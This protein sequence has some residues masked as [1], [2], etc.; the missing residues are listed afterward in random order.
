MEITNSKFNTLPEQVQENKDNINALNERIMS[1]NVY[2]AKIE[3]AQDASAILAEDIKNFDASKTNGYVLDTAGKLFKIVAVDND[4]VYID[5]AATL[6]RG[7]QGERG[8]RGLTGEVGP[9][10]IQGLTGEVGPVGPR[11][12]QGLTGATGDAGVGI[13]SI[14]AGTPSQS[15]NNTVTP[16]TITLTNGNTQL[17][18]IYATNG[19]DG[20]QGNSFIITG[21]VNSVVDLPDVSTVAYGTA[22]YVGTTY[23]RDVFVVVEYQGAKIWQNEGKL[24]GP[25]GPVGPVGATGANGIN[26][27]DGVGIASITAGTPS[28]SG[29]NTVTPLTITLT[30]NNTVNFNVEAQNGQD[31]AQGPQGV[32]GNTGATGAT[33]D[34]GVGI[35]S[36][37]AGTPTVSGTTTTTPLT[38]TLTNGNTQTINVEAQNGQDGATGPEGP[39]GPA[40]E[41]T[42]VDTFILSNR[43]QIA[44]SGYFANAYTYT[45]DKSFTVEQNTH[46]FVVLEYTSFGYNQVGYAYG[47]IGEYYSGFGNTKAP[48]IT[49]YGMGTT[50]VSGHLSQST[51]L[52]VAFPTTTSSDTVTTVEIGSVASMTGNLPQRMSIYKM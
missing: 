7:A 26:G 33:G 12:I 13:A 41:Y 49:L 6:P 18:Y 29:N 2:N 46:Y 39:Q 4:T 24:Q 43:T 8:E 45:L 27:I 3:I 30:N 44:N 40:G 14:V 17:I 31:G 34:A 11:G 51:P 48:Y 36:I 20:S 21:S 16:L 52:G 5:Y 42:L 32:P 15:G 38:I 19:T 50:S 10:G 35:A 25:T 9:R 28:Q 23:P 37:V 47:Y 1:N 22:Y